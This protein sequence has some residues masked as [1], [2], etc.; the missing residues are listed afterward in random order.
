MRIQLGNCPLPM[1][2][3]NNGLCLP[4]MASHTRMCSVV[5]SL[6]YDIMLSM[7]F[8]I[9]CFSQ[10]KWGFTLTLQH[11]NSLLCGSGLDASS[12]GWKEKTKEKLRFLLK[13]FQVVLITSNLPQMDLFGLLYFRYK[14]TCQMCIEQDLIYKL[15]KVCWFKGTKKR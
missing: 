13:T 3:W 7:L 1:Y 8:I 12:I 6:S 10:Q 14:N 9:L 5:P 2:M 4:F 11:A 15:R